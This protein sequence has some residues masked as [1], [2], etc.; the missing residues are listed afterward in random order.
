M[1]EMLL[2]YMKVRFVNLVHDRTLYI[3]A[4]PMTDLKEFAH[5][6]RKYAYTSLPE[7]EYRMRDEEIYPE[8]T[9]DEERKEDATDYVDPS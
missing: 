8:G 6:N 5:D 2:T 9:P 1:Q 4:V 3:Y 7:D